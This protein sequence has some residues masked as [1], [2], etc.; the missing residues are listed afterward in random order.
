ML[1]VFA[2]G[3][4]VFDYADQRGWMGP[5]SPIIHADPAIAEACGRSSGPRLTTWT[6]CPALPNE[7][8]TYNPLL[9]S[10]DLVLPLVDLQQEKD[11]APIVT[12]NGSEW[13]WPRALVRF[14]TGLPPTRI[15]PRSAW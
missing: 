5:T 11:W 4:H 2:L 13:T 8:T 1:L 10:L 6:I 15:S 14:Y 9:Y 7:Y 3:H 12:V